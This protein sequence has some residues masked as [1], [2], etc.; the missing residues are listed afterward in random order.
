MPASAQG[1]TITF[2]G[3]EIG[4]LRGFDSNHEAGPLQDVTSVYA[5]VLGSGDDTRTMREYDCT[6][7]EPASLSC[8][9]YGSG[10][11]SHDDVGSKAL[12]EFDSPDEYWYSEAILTGWSHGGS[13][14]EF[15]TGAAT[16]QLTG[17]GAGSE[18]S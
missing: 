10:P 17:Q 11:F 8:T 3:V 4:E 7:V 18:G 9:F 6:S 16:F 2:G 12:L 5:G 14:G 1:T 15:A 13:V